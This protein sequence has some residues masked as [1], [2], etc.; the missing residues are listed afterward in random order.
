MLTTKPGIYAYA[1]MPTQDE[2]GNPPRGC[3]VAFS[4]LEAKGKNGVGR[5]RKTQ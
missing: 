2:V 5:K 4:S 3:D 1:P